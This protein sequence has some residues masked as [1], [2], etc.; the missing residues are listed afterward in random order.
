M[1]EGATAGSGEERLRTL[2]GERARL[3]AFVERRVGSR[4]LAEEILQD[5]FVRGVEKASEV[6]ADESVL[7]W[8]Y[9]LLRNSIIDRRRRTAANTR[10]TTALAAEHD[11][12]GAGRLESDAERG[13]ICSCMSELIGTLKPEYETAIRSVDLEGGTV[14]QLAAATGI[15]AGN[16]AVRLHRARQALGQRLRST[17]GACAEHACLDCGCKKNSKV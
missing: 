5:A 13:E 7:A 14:G 2:L 9:R 17:C 1:S 3:L 16:A 12:F 11:A 15:S 6:R 10:A 4:E 8:F